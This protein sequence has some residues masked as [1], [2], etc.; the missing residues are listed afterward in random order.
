MRAGW[1]YGISLASAWDA[2]KQT[3]DGWTFQDEFSPINGTVYSDDRITSL[4]N[5]NA[6]PYPPFGMILDSAWHSWKFVVRH[7]LVTVTKDGNALGEYPLARGCGGVLLRVWSE[8][9]EFRAVKLS[10]TS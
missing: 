5:P 7:G 3:A 4:A 6:S 10:V 2:V 8:R 1:G 9:A